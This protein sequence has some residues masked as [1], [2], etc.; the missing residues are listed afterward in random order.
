[1]WA[2]RMFT[3]TFLVSSVIVPVSSY[4]LS[5]FAPPGL[6]SRICLINYKK[7]LALTSY[8]KG[9]NA[10]ILK[11]PFKFNPDLEKVST[12]HIIHKLMELIM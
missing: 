3:I 1:M 8:Y 5:T 9:R 11:M 12:I 2:T 10:G 4:S 6:V 7:K